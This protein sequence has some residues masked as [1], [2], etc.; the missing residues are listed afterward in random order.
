[1]ATAWTK[2]SFERIKVEADT[3]RLDPEDLNAL[4]FIENAG[5]I[6][7]T[8]YPSGNPNPRKFVEHLVDLGLATRTD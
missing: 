1:M 5:T 3:Y 7:I 2:L 4:N 8:S 6:T